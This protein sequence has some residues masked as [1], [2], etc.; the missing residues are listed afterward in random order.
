[1]DLEKSQEEST[2]VKKSLVSSQFAI[3]ELEKRYS[4]NISGLES[5]LSQTRSQIQVLSTRLDD[6]LTQERVNKLKIAQVNDRLFESL[7]KIRH[8]EILASKYY[9]YVESRTSA[10]VFNYHSATKETSN[11]QPA[12]QIFESMRKE[13]R[14]ALVQASNMEQKLLDLESRSIAT[15]LELEQQ[16]TAI[17]VKLLKATDTI[18]VQANEIQLLNDKLNTAEK[19]IGVL[20]AKMLH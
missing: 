10:S 3:T 18:Q 9:T 5:Q 16:V 12:I 14:D 20:H 15:H 6:A 2:L 19:I 8:L 1:M 17:S 7:E 4:D 13:K 11:S